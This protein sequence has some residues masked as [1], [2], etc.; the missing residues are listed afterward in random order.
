[1]HQLFYK[2]KMHRTIANTGSRTHLIYTFKPMEM[3]PHYPMESDYVA[4]C[5]VGEK[6]HLKVDRLE[7]HGCFEREYDAK[8]IA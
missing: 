7:L 3:R 6:M 2:A 1:M 8:T 4:S 5:P